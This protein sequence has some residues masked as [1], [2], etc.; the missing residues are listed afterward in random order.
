LGGNAARRG[1]SENPAESL[2]G[3]QLQVV[4]TA[5]DNAHA[6][7]VTDV[8]RRLLAYPEVQARLDQLAAL[9]REGKMLTYTSELAQIDNALKGVWTGTELDVLVAR[10]ELVPAQVAYWAEAERQDPTLDIG[11]RL[12]ALAD[13]WKAVA[14]ARETVGGGLPG[15]GFTGGRP[16]GGPATATQTVELVARSLALQV[17]GLNAADADDR[18]ADEHNEGRPDRYWTTQSNVRVYRKRLRD[19]LNG[20]SAPQ[21]PPC[22][23]EWRKPSAALRVE[24]ELRGAVAWRDESHECVIC[25]ALA[26]RE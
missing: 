25:G 4:L 23:H 8:R 1:H 24:L 26:L 18:T 15:V 12:A 7:L 21:A 10:H 20:P 6:A 14:A 13:H 5:K 19:R 9:R 3:S 22:E 16:P 17:E 2:S 11:E